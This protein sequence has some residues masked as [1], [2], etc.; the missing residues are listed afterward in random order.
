MKGEI[1]V[2]RFFFLHGYVIIPVTGLVEQEMFLS[3]IWEK[4]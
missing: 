1:Y 3:S 4:R 2:S